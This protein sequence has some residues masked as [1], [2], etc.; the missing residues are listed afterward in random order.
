MP[1]IVVSLPDSGEVTFELT[2]ETITLGR[3][4]DNT[5][6]IEDGSVSSYH[7]TL[8]QEGGN[9][10]LKDNNSTNGTFV[11]GQQGTEWLLQD[12]DK[13]V[14]GNIEG[15]YHSE[16]AATARPLPQTNE[17]SVTVGA[18]SAKPSN[19]TNASPFKTKKKPKDPAGMA[20]MGFS[21]VAILA[22]VGALG[23]IFTLQA[24]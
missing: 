10:R 17:H 12:G 23:L 14:F 1:K 16:V 18:S 2:D 3:Q 21:I 5:A 15:T 6:Q 24:P 20:M 13:V 22:F 8:T 9:Y 4:P 11:N 7:A 19:F